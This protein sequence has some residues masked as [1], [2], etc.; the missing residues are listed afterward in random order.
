MAGNFLTKAIGIAA[1]GIAGYDTVSSAKYMAP[2]YKRRYRVA[3][4]NDVYMNTSGLGSCSKWD[5]KMQTWS[6]R[7]ALDN[8]IFDTSQSIKSKIVAFSKSFFN[9]AGTIALG[10]MALFTGKGKMSVLKIPYLNNIAAA[11]L[12]LKA[13]KTVVNNALGIGGKDYRSNLIDY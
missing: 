6:R 2:K 8:N 12:A 10:A 11:L 3:Q 4:L 1:L 7:W 9:N 5:S 13:G